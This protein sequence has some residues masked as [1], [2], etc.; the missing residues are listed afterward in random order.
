MSSA[1]KA[2][3]NATNA[4]PEV[5]AGSNPETTKPFAPK[6]LGCDSSLNVIR[7]GGWNGTLDELQSFDYFRSQTS[8]D[9]AYS[10]NTS[11]DE[12][13]LQ[14]SHRYDPIRHAAIALGALGMVIRFNSGNPEHDQ[15]AAL[16]RHQLARAQY[17]KAIRILQ[18]EI[19]Q[20]GNERVDLVLI[21]CF[22]FIVFEFLQGND[23]TAT[24]HLRSGLSILRAQYFSPNRI[25]SSCREQSIAGLGPMQ[26]EIA[27]IFH[28]LDKQATMWFELRSLGG[29]TRVPTVNPSSQ[30]TTPSTYSSLA[31]AHQDLNSLIIRIHDFQR[32]TSQHQYTTATVPASFYTRRDSLLAALET[33]RRR[34]SN[35]VAFHTSTA[36]SREVLDLQHIS[37]LRI[38]RKVT[39]IILAACLESNKASFYAQSTWQFWQIVS[40]ATLML[41]P[42]TLELRQKFLRMVHSCYSETT[43]CGSRDDDSAP[44]KQDVHL[45][46]TTLNGLIH[47]LYFTATKCRERATAERAVKLLE[48]EPWREGASYSATLA[49]AARKEMAHF[50]R[51]GWYEME[52]EDRLL[53]AAS[54]GVEGIAKGCGTSTGTYFDGDSDALPTRSFGYSWGSNNA[55]C[56]TRT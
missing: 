29:T 56:N 39:T 14:T 13:V 19:M 55:E 20:K 1:M 50:Q 44:E 28:I 18:C 11:L 2:D 34:L 36:H 33:H 4:K 5:A 26:L 7:P 3:L 27:R 8:E 40:L 35:Y 46:Q 53:V 54:A 10:L 23:E 52:D 21:S 47:P 16:W 51:K 42:E 25:N 6:S 31:E 41:R 12:L 37:I 22:L 9:L 49:K 17:F 48:M 38:N 30:A 24:R 43:L 32:H 45:T 15:T